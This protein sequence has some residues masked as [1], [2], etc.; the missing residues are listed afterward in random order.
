MIVNSGRGRPR[1]YS[2][3]DQMLQQERENNMRQA[4]NNLI[5]QTL[6]YELL[7]A[8][9]FTET[10]SNEP[11]N[12]EMKR[13]IEDKLIAKY[14]IEGA[15]AVIRFEENT[16][17]LKDLLSEYYRMKQIEW[18]PCSSSINKCQKVEEME[19]D[20]L[21][22]T[23][24]D[25]ADSE[26][27]I[28]TPPKN[29]RTNYLKFKSP[30][31]EFKEEGWMKLSP[32]AQEILKE[33][34]HVIFNEDVCYQEQVETVISLLYKD[35]GPSAI[36]HLFGVNR[37]TIA[38]HKKRL[39]KK[40]RDEVGRPGFL[41]PNELQILIIY[42]KQLYEQKRPAD[43]ADLVNFIFGKFE[44][45]MSI[46]TLAHIIKRTPSLKAIVGHPLEAARNDVDVQIIVDY[47][48]RLDSILLFERVPPEFFFNVD[49]SGFQEFINAHDT[50]VIVPTEYPSD[51]IT[52]SVNRE[53]KRA[54]MIGCIAMDGSA[55]KPLVVSQNKTIE[56]ELI[57]MG[58]NN[59]NCFIITQPNGFVNAEIFALWADHVF[60]PELE[61][62][63]IVY[64]Y[65]GLAV[66]TMDGCGSHFSDYVLDEC[67]YHGTYPSQE[68]A[69]TS[70][71]IQALDLGIFGIQKVLKPKEK[72]NIKNISRNS[73]QIV[74][75]VN[76]W[77]KATTPSNVV[78]AFQQA[79][80][81]LEEINDQ[82]YVR[83]DVMKARSVR[84]LDHSEPICE[85]TGKK[86]VKLLKF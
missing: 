71:Q 2:L 38:E 36:G 66:L 41:S 1:K 75:I 84:G 8:F 64:N 78:S 82:R 61:R 73:K 86:S 3:R 4:I 83:A 51:E 53:G 44:I 67:T 47:Y 35:I 68:P 6:D 14:G 39:E 31:T 28:N 37:G 24:L 70:D 42:V 22:N 7:A 19:E 74:Q 72:V 52:Y 58:Y 79:G 29:A 60:F 40:R 12:E 30:I 48:E 25:D 77:R 43:Y 11:Q 46:D 10:H 65:K 49:E 32:D 80:F 50:V 57:N 15:E 9:Y 34:S 13:K 81:Y 26:E 63:R 27:V 18:R 21:F 45:A 59:E 55:L 16:Q 69:G 54:S 5:D 62:R 33:N 85:A 23:S 76:S 17:R 20:D 56:K